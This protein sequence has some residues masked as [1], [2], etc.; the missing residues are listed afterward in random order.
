M[1]ISKTKTAGKPIVG[2]IHSGGVDSILSGLFRSIMFNLHIDVPKFSRLTDR[3]IINAGIPYNSK[4]STSEKGNLK[5][6]L[7]SEKMSWKVFIKGLCFLN[8]VKF[9]LMIRLHHHNGCITE[10]QK[11]VVL[12]NR[13]DAPDNDE[14]NND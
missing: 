8:I 12:A 13:D 4:K 7:L 10:H 1:R 6:E 3:Y 5:K 2:P 11:T 9:D 14:T